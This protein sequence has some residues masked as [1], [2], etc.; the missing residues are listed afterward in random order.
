MRRSWMFKY[1]YRRADA[2]SFMKRLQ[3]LFCIFEVRATTGVES[4]VGVCAC[5]LPRMMAWFD[6]Q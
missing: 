4:D 1:V 2:T 3:E 5:L 6:M